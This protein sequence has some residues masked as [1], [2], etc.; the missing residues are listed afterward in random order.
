MAARTIAMVVVIV[1][2]ATTIVGVNGEDGM[3]AHARTIIATTGVA[4]VTAMIA[5]TITDGGL[6]TT[7]H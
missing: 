5:G 6:I 4:G 7:G 1:A 3:T 2:M